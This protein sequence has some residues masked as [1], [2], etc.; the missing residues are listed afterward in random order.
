VSDLS[1]DEKRELISVVG[2]D[3]ESTAAMIVGGFEVEE[4]GVGNVVNI[5]G[6]HYSIGFQLHPIPEEKAEEIKENLE[7]ARQQQEG[8]S[9]Q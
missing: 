2:K 4:I 3:I 9:S 8:E 7:Q 1:G 6:Q 5:Q